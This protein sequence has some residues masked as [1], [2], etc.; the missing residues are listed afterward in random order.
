MRDFSSRPR[1]RRLEPREW[2]WLAVGA[3]AVLLSAG[4]AWDAW[5]DNRAAVVRVATVRAERDAAGARLRALESQVRRDS[6][7]N[8]AWLTLEAPPPRVVADLAE[9]LPPEVRLEQ[10][11]LKYGTRL[12]VEMT[13]SARDAAAYDLFL[14]RLGASPRFGEV[15]PGEE[16]RA[17]EVKA[18]VRAAYREED[19]R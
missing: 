14:E 19:A 13:V 12:E 9:L 10:L 1:A 16:N 15:S 6:M 2:A 17:G 4:T 7:G 3:L 5:R 11:S 8:Q 18:Q